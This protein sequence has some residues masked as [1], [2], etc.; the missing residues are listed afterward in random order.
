MLIKKLAFLYGI[1]LLMLAVF[2]FSLPSLAVAEPQTGDQNIS[3]PFLHLAAV[4][5]AV[6]GKRSADEKGSGSDA[7]H[8]I[9]I[10]IGQDLNAFV[11]FSH[12]AP[13]HVAQKNTS[14]D[15]RTLFG[16]HITLK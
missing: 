16:F 10:P 14:P 13:D 6:Y 11:D 7:S 4:G 9:N 8:A 1:P 15:F 5:P 12:T 2:F 3:T